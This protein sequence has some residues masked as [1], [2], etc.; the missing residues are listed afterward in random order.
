MA[1]AHPT[2]KHADEA[3]AAL[4]DM[5]RHLPAAPWRRI[6]NA[7]LLRMAGWWS[8]FAGLLAL[9]SVC[10]ICGGA[11][12]PVGVGTTGIIAGLLAGAK[13][14]GGRIIGMIREPVQKWKQNENNAGAGPALTCHCEGHHHHTPGPAQTAHWS[15]Q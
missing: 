9:N 11:S 15:K 4:H 13:V 6:I 2:M 12:C 5:R 14:F 3:A 8:I 7:G 10:P 1:D